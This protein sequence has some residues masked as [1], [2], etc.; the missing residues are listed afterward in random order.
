[1]PSGELQRLIVDHPDHF[2]YFALRRA[3]LVMGCS[4]SLKAVLP[5]TSDQLAALE[6]ADL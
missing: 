4:H 2:A 5:L 1:M 3:V 6:A